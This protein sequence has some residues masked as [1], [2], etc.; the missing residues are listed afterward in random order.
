MVEILEHLLAEARI[1]KSL[2]EPE[3][4]RLLRERAGL[5]QD[6]VAR[7]LGV[8]RVAVTRYE[9]GTRSPRGRLRVEYAQLLERLAQEVIVH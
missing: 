4:R 8:N 7:V 5:T 2:P 6:E 3:I 9:G 1:R